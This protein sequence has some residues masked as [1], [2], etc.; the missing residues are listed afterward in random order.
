MASAFFSGVEVAFVSV[1][2]IKARSL[3][4]QKK[5]GSKALLRLKADSEN[6]LI[7][8]LIGTNV[9]NVF[10]SGLAAY[11]AT[12]TMGEIGLGIAMGVMTF[13]VL[14]FGEITP[15]T[16]ASAHSERIAL[17]LARPVEIIK[18]LMKPLVL[19]LGF[20]TEF[21][22]SL[23]QSKSLPVLTEHDLKTVVEVGYE[24]KVLD[25]KDRDIIAGVIRFD[26][27]EVRQVMT[28]KSR[29][30]SL[31]EDLGLSDALKRFGQ[32]KFSRALVH[33]K[34]D[35]NDIQGIVNLRDIVRGYF[36]KKDMPISEIS[37]RAFRTPHNKRVNRL[38]IDMQKMH[39]HMSVV[40]MEGEYIGIVTLEDIIE[41]ILGEIWDEQDIKPEMIVR[42]GKR[43]YLV[44]A[45]TRLETLEDYLNVCIEKDN[46]E[47]NVGDYV[48]KIA[49]QGK[50]ADASGLTFEIV[51]IEG[52]R[53]RTVSVR[54]SR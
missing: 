52:D 9:A 50:K 44:H 42:S 1:N 8:I 41:E 48:K 28:P 5:K 51:D 19:A 17:S 14:I 31:S 7:S 12:N 37:R 49:G 27:I 46:C 25:E 29:V 30:F 47:M 2:D 22:S 40:D 4:E 3:A 33:K 11:I 35:E 23:S 45:K 21:I 18:A 32:T 43:S 10:A 38:L 39:E 13:M 54:R 24:Q 34:E 16:Y 53:I 6:T 15:K 20:I 36:S 26:D